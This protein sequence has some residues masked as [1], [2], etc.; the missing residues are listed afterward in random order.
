MLVLLETTRK[1]PQKKDFNHFSVASSST[2]EINNPKIE[3][4]NMTKKRFVVGQ[5]KEEVPADFDVI[6]F[7]ENITLDVDV[8]WG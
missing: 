6:L 3:E 2:P 7:A 4:D 1:L 8:Y 5:I